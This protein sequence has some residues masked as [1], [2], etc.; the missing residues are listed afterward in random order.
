MGFLKPGK[1]RYR[2]RNESDEPKKTYKRR[3]VKLEPPKP[4]VEEIHIE[5]EE[6][7]DKNKSILEKLPTEIIHEIFLI[8]GLIT[9]PLVCKSLHAKLRPTRSLKVSMLKKSIVDLNSGVV[10]GKEFNERYALEKQILDFKFVT[11]GILKEVH[12]DTVLPNATIKSEIKNRLILYNDKLNKTLLDIM[13]RSEYTEEQIN[14]E[15]ADIADNAFN[16][17]AVQGQELE[18]APE[19]EIQDFPMRFYHGPFD[20]DRL[21]MITL[22]HSKGLRYIGSDSILSIAMDC[23]VEISVLDKLMNCCKDVNIQNVQPLITA[24]DKGNMSYVDWVVSN[25]ETEE[26]LNHDDLWV[27]IYQTQDSSYLHFLESRGATPSH[28][29]LGMLSST[30]I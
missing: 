13:R 3:R 15:L 2:A 29:V 23:D 5:E 8:G 25:L 21:Q 1:N 24:F 4:K 27:Y 20:Q 14:R 28:D 9:L 19:Q 12:F 7:Y 6:E 22:L 10:T 11:Y 30:H 17:L 26:L 18:D 16:N